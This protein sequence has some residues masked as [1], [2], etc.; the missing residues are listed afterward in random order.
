M[1]AF[2]YLRAGLVTTGNIVWYAATSG[3]YL[4]LEGRVRGG[5]FQNWARGSGTR[6]RSTRARPAEAEI[7]ELVKSARSLRVFGIGS[8]LQRRHRV[9]R[10]L[11]VSLD[12][13]SGLVR[14]RT[15]SGSRSRS[16]GGT[17]IR[18]VVQT[19]GRRGSG[20]SGP[21][22]P[23]RAEH[24]R[25]PLHRRPRHGS[26][27]GLRQR[28]GRA[29]DPGGR[30]RGRAPAASRPTSCSAPRSAGSGRSASSPRSSCRACRGSTSSRRSRCGTSATCG[31]TSTSC[32]PRTSTSAC[33]CT[34][35]ATPARSTPGTAPTTS[36][37]PRTATCASS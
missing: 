24:R 22:V 15:W 13:F 6:R 2:S 11:L 34:R 35:S 32:W 10:D 23:R 7:V 17:R 8:L 37:R 30:E 12:H 18:D 33:T 27:L 29:A 36:R 21:A 5:V 20:L 26:G 9:G 16:R 19:P 4:S 31:S 28:V 14:P 25:H 1:K 3:R